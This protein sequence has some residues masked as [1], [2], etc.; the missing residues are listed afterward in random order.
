VRVPPVLEG[1]GAQT[2]L[3]LLAY[4]VF[5]LVLTWPLTAH[6][7]STVYLTPPNPPGPG[8]VGG[9]IAH[10][11]ELV[12]G[13]HNP[14]LPGR[15]HDFDAPNGLPIRWALNIATFPSVALLYVL[16]AAFG[17]T[18]AYGLF[19]LLG[20]V[21][22]G[23]SMFLLVRWLTR[24][25]WIAFIAG[26]A[27]AFYPFA[28]VKGEHPNFLHGWVF[29]VM[30]WRF[31]VLVERPTLRN[32]VWAGLASVLCFAWTQYFILLGGIAFW[33]LVVATVVVGAVR[34]RLR[35]HALAVLPAIAIALGFVLGARALLLGSSE[36]ETLPTTAI[37][38]IIATSAR[39]PMYLVPPAHHLL[40][41]LTLSYLN[42][43]RFNSVEWTLYVGLS[44]LALALVGFVAACL[45]R[46]RPELVTAAAISTALV[47]VG[48]VFSLPPEKTFA[49]VTVHLPS[50]LIYHASSSWRLYTRFVMVVMLGICVLAALGLQALLDGKSARV[51][52]AILSMAT[53]IIPLDLW[54]RP[55]V[56]TF[57]LDPPRIYQALRAQPPGIVA[58]Y[59]L[60]SVAAV[61]HYRDLYYQSAH[62]KPILNGYY[63]GPDERRALRLDRLDYPPTARWLSTLDVRYVLVTPTTLLPGV[64]SPGKPGRGFR[65][66]AHDSYGTLY[67]VTATPAP[68]VWLRHGFWGPEGAGANQRQ[69][70]GKGTVQLGVEG[71]CAPCQGVLSFDATSFGRPRS[72]A[73]VSESGK[74][75]V[76]VKIPIKSVVVRA[77]LSFDR[78]TTVDL[79][80]SPGPQVINETIP[81]STDN[82]EVSVMVQGARFRLFK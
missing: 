66:I 61:G 53:I 47:V 37:V 73:V 2:A 40:S 45:R 8:D 38:D 22:S 26:W 23:V 82:R 41:G 34:S 20:Y 59:P 42:R 15:E 21:A 17:A 76:R 31:L 67:R 74:T 4:A 13:H 78:H 29:V 50:W 55:D 65:P 72:L 75:L 43:H 63:A 5:A 44:V 24:S 6:L 9:S 1:R 58:E 81:G 68:F 11:R 39:V 60:R 7:G 51:Q 16:A 49:G 62:G 46:F 18:A 70:A 25:A 27:F 57:R 12:H 28:V 77:P 30:L 14:F 3:A 19:D 10:L 48:F 69:W 36:N 71:K 52:F 64:P 80:I 33:T 79:K 35:E 56:H 32:G 54:D